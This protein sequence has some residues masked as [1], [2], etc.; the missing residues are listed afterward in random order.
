MGTSYAHGPSL[1]GQL[2]LLV[3]VRYMTEF[4]AAGLNLAHNSATTLCRQQPLT[5]EG[6]HGEDALMTT[7]QRSA[8]ATGVC[9]GLIRKRMS[10]ASSPPTPSSSMTCVSSLLCFA[11]TSSFHPGR[12]RSFGT[13]P[14]RLLPKLLHIHTAAECY[15]AAAID[16]L[17]IS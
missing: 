5:E 9:T 6:S 12:L 17:T 3:H 8:L 4:K 10:D 1:V 14:L 11:Y 16:H 7:A 15:Y 13:F 2:L